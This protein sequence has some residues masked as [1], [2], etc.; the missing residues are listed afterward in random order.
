M[1]EKTI[2]NQQGEPE[3]KTTMEPKSVAGTPVPVPATSALSTI[4]QWIFILGIIVGIYFLGRAVSIKIP[5]IHLKPH[6]IIILAFS[7]SFTW[8]YV[9]KWGSVKP[10]SCITCMS[11]WFALIIG[12]WSAGWW[13]I[14]YIPIAMTVA[15]LY[16]EIRMRW[17]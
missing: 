4:I 6:Y 11:G 10:F 5:S 3:R 8:V 14:A 2:V 15:A 9:F 16:S 17:L 12:Y 7:F 1:T 13:G